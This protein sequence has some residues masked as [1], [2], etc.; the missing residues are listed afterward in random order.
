M[1][2]DAPSANANRCNAEF[3]DKWTKGQGRGQHTAAAAGKGCLR[4]AESCKKTVN[5]QQR[6][7]TVPVFPS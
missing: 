7:Y 3:N 1:G 4:K 6:T 5:W 2:L